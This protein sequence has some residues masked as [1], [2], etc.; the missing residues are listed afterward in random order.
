MRRRNGN[1]R[2]RKERMVRIPLRFPRHGRSSRGGTNT[3]WVAKPPG[4]RCRC[5]AA[6]ACAVSSIGGD[7]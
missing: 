5:R 2:G 4:G 1:V 3:A 7:D 6:A